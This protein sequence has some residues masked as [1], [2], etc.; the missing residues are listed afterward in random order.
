MI[1]TERKFKAI[2][3]IIFNVQASLHR[4][5]NQIGQLSKIL[6]ELPLI[7]ETTVEVPSENNNEKKES[8]AKEEVEEDFGILGIDGVRKS[9]I[10]NN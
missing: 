1:H 7:S 8:N 10:N 6:A 3:A 2:N 5:E 9:D 4:V